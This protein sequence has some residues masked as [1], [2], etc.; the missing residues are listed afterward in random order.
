MSRFIE[1]EDRH[2][3][4]L[5]PESLDEYIAELY[6]Y[7]YLDRIQ[8]SRRSEREA[9]RNVEKKTERLNDKINKL[10]QEMGRLKALEVEMMEAPDEKV[11]LTDPDARSMD[12]TVAEAPAWWTITFKQ[13]SILNII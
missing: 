6:V 1:R 5:F 10:K 7:G 8:S 11:S 12:T 4:T 2:Q 13:P 3:V 9:Q